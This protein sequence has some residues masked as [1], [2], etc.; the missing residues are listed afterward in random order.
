M[1]KTILAEN[2]LI[3]GTW[4]KDQVLTIENGVIANI[5]TLSGSQT[6]REAFSTRVH[7]KLIPGFVDTQVN[8][9]GGVMFNHAPTF[10]SIEIM[11][12]AHREFGTTTLF[13]TLITDDIATIE[14]AANA[15]SEA[16]ESGNPSVEGIH[17]EGPHLSVEKKGVHL[18]K[19][20]RPLTDRELATYTRK[21]LGKVMITVAPEN[22]S[23]DVIRD[24][25]NQGVIVALGH[26]N[27]PFEVVERA[28]EAGA[29][30]FTHLYNA[31][32]PFTSREPGMVGAALLSNN[33][34]GII[35]DHQHLH[36]K[37]VELAFK[38]K[39]PSKLML[40]TDAMAHVGADKDVI[41]FFDTHITRVGNKLTT[42]DG[43]LAGSC[44]D[45]HGAVINCVN[46]I[47][48]SL[49]EASLMASATPSAFMGINEKVGS[50]AVGQ[51][52]NFVELSE[53][54]ALAH[55][56]QNGEVCV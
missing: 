54:N 19:Y 20:I 38:T 40:V 32:S 37:A 27:A 17:F 16:I 50:I 4:E 2:I 12:K 47:G 24:L 46:D 26:S 23:C 36:P 29:T 42:P 39:G 18:S 33:T 44:L 35:V 14:S 31:M 7:N 15:V 56:W 49:K 53:D 1:M 25:V 21:D 43:T 51:R 10:K 41:D 45:M 48:I 6:H 5:E 34:C 28:I 11:A 22:T 3:K 52:A 9:G 55:V 30:G 8:G 13:P